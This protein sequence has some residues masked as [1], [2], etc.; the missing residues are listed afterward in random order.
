MG[1]NIIMRPFMKKKYQMSKNMKT[2][3]TTQG[4]HASIVGFSHFLYFSHSE[5]L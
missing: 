4:A 2:M 3:K 5:E 1:I